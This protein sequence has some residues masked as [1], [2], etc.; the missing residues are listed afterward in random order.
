MQLNMIVLVFIIVIKKDLYSCLLPIKVDR[1]DT[2]HMDLHML[3]LK[4]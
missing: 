4:E 2:T 1:E 3:Q